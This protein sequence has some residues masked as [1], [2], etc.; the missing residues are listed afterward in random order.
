MG[1]KTVKIGKI[2]LGGRSPLALIAGPCVIESRESC[3]DLAGRLVRLS[4]R[5]DIPLIFKA[6][7]D[8]ANRT[9]IHSYRGPG[10]DAGLEILS[11]IRERFSV[12]VLTDVHTAEEARMAGRVVDCLQIPAFL[13]RQTDLLVAAAKTGVPVNVK[14]GQFLSAAEMKHVVGKLEESG[15][16]R[17][18]LTER[19]ES[20]GYQNLVADMRNLPLLSQ[21]GR[22]VVFDATHSVQRPGAGDGASGGDRWLAP[23]LARA[24]VAAGCD[25]VFIETHVD[26]DQALS[27]GANAI[28]FKDLRLLWRKLRAIDAVVAGRS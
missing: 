28:I 10:I 24:A 23:Y 17:I 9:S 22:P 14:K 16:K 26:P 7:Y 21:L 11:E 15:A 13:C 8:K 4:A 6:S 2:S 5:E 27:D 12:P 19:G 25:A 3:L 18:L 20:F 1:S